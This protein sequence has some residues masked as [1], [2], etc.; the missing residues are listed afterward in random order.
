MEI[1]D[2]AYFTGQSHK[3]FFFKGKAKLYLTSEI[4]VQ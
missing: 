2:A 3:Y 1:K 4:V